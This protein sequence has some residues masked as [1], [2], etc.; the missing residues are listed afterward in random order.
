MSGGEK[1]EG[2]EVNTGWEDVASLASQARNLDYEGESFGVD[3]SSETIERT[4]RLD[5]L[6]FENVDFTGVV[7]RTFRVAEEIDIK[8]LSAVRS[9][10]QEDL[11]TGLAKAETYLSNVLKLSLE[12]YLDTSRKLGEGVLGSCR[13]GG[14]YADRIS[15]DL[16]QHDGNV[17]SILETLGHENWHSFQHDVLRR[18]REMKKQ[19]EEFPEELA[20][21]AELYEYN[22]KFYVRSDLDYVEYCKQLYEVEAETFGLFIKMKL[23]K[24]KAEEAKRDE[25][26][27]SYPEV[28]GEEN[29]LG[30]EREI[31]GVLRGMDMDGFLERA[32]VGSLDELWDT[33]EN[34]EITKGYAKSLS[35]LVGLGR[36]VEVKF[37]DR[38]DDDNKSMVDYKNHQITISR[39]QM[40]SFQPVSRL[41]EIIWKMRQCDVARDSPESERGRLYRINFETYIQD[42][43][44]NHEAYTKQL[45]VRENNYFVEELLNIL[46]EQAMEEE[47]EMMPSEERAMAREEQ[48]RAGWM[49][50]ASQK[51]G[52]KRRRIDGRE[53]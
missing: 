7:E 48:E 6:V 17:D 18:V 29:Q 14:D 26:I 47:I 44:V 25:I 8:D 46:D 32:G 4:R 2:G 49:P 20:Q 11:E 37:E 34:E 9:E 38:L 12:P 53:N 19:G 43:K 33:N 39:E 50:L 10:L 24:I 52:V 23:D 36:P 45:L 21:L 30:I 35:N 31:D 16:E 22:G 13:N 51:Y 1:L 5:E 40:W 27:A 41:P 28:Y 3:D 15:V 42:G